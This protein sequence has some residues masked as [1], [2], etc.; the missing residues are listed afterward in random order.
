M[1]W[2]SHFFTGLPQHAWKAAQTDEQ[3]QL[4]LERIVE[5][6]EFGPDDRVLDVFCGYGRHALPLAKM[7]ADVVGVDIS[8]ESI[9]ELKTAVGRKKIALTAV[10]GDFMTIDP[11]LLGE[12]GSFQAAYCLGNSLCF[13]PRHQMVLFL[14]RIADLLEP[15][16][17]FLAQS[18]MVAES[19]LPDFQERAWLPVGDDIQVLVHNQYDPFTACVTQHLTYYRRSKTGV[20][21][22]DRTAQYYI[23][24]VAD[25]LALF[26]EAGLEPT[27]CFGTVEGDSYQI[28]DEGAW[29]TAVK[30]VE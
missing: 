25:L 9:T 8:D 11:A 19:F 1:S 2:Y 24:T 12:P 7:G 10:A 21:V 28:G 20:D 22:V 27:A 30:K 6:L 14:Q 29:I 16:G 5:S 26:K 13:F 3:T 17:R 15:G 4:E 23:Y 18:G